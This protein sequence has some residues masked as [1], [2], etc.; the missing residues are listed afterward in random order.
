[1]I[2]E[3][4]LSVTTPMCLL[5]MLAGTVIGIAF[6][7]VPGLTSTMAVA[8]CLPLTYKMSTI[9][10]IAFLISLYVGGISGGLI[11]AILIN[12]PGTPSSV[13]TCFDG[14]PMAK[15][16]EAGK[17]LGV[18]ICSS[19]VG[20]LLSIA[21]LIFIAPTLA[22]LALKFGPYEYFAVSI[23]ALTM[24]S[25]LIS[26]SILR[27]LTAAVL[28]VLV[29]LFGIAPTGGTLRFTFGFQELNLGFSTLP[30]LIGLF[31]VAEVFAHS[32]NVPM[33]DK[34]V[35]IVDYKIKGFGFTKEE[36][37]GQIWNCLRSSLIGIGI[38]ILPGIGGGTSNVIAYSVAKQ[39]S[40]H[41]EKFGTGIIDG[42]VASES[43]NN[44]SIG[45]AMIP[46]LTLG[47][48]GDAVTAILLGGLV[49]KGITPGPLLFT[50]NGVFVYGIFF[51]LGISTL[52]MF[53]IEFFG[54]RMFVNVLKIP[55]HYLLP[56]VMAL[57][58]VG[59]FG[60]NSW[61]FDVWASLIFGVVGFLLNRFRFPVSPF[62]LG[63]LLGGV[64][65][66]NLIRS[67]QYASGSVIEAYLQAPIAMFF[68]IISFGLVG[69]KTFK[70]LINRKASKKMA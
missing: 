22:R 69:Y 34:N 68:L 7:S 37:K 27:G 10:G 47:I 14:S 21:A 61:I 42:I 20:T 43:A 23:F 19:V 52:M 2:T 16:G 53:V 24:I 33:V 17:A 51:A 31:A 12:I 1:M 49:M 59:T 9:V 39:Q 18:G 46:L 3:A 15:N 62:I 30:V 67:I 13:A 41:P 57:C 48:P 56:I 26:D 4:L 64:V 65:E 25:S 70:A 44:A 28:G 45:G 32:M 54:I 63:F 55:K 29:S 50:N 66:Q 11:S 60:T 6:G 38:G 40:K 35:Q 5:L 8:L 58:C 36:A